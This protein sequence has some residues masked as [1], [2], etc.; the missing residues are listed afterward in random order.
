MNSQD[1]KFPGKI[2][3]MI[4]EISGSGG[5]L[6]GR[7]CKEHISSL[8]VHGKLKLLNWTAISWKIMYGAKQDLYL[9]AMYVQTLSYV[10]MYVEI[11][12][13][14]TVNS[15]SEGCVGQNEKKLCILPD[16]IAGTSY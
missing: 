10:C 13:M 16:S 5:P 8:Q 1:S 2:P 9:V 3:A 4:Y 11:T 6:G 12:I 7:P 15:Y 14:V